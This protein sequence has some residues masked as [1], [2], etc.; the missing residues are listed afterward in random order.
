MYIGPGAH[1]IISK[2]GNDM[3]WLLTCKVRFPPQVLLSY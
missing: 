3:C 1:I 2:S